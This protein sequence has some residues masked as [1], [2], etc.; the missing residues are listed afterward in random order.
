MNKENRQRVE[1]QVQLGWKVPVAAKE[2]FASFCSKVGSVTQD[3]CAGALTIWP[4]L[5]SE[6]REQA[7]LA[8]KGLVEVEPAFWED[9]QAGLRMALR[10]QANN[11]Q[12]KRGKKS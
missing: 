6:I 5:P 4:Y 10:A 3:D 2:T 7:K 12:G 9:F 8:A 1:Q 11:P